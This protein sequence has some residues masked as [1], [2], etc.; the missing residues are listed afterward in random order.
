MNHNP[1]KM[2]LLMIAAALVAILLAKILSVNILFWLVL[3]CPVM[4]I[5][6]MFGRPN[7]HN[8]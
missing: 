3:L 2:M 8:H 4:M 6:M 7:N 5:A 1:S